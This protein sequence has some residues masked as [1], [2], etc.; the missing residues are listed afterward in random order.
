MINFDFDSATIRE[1]GKPVIDGLAQALQRC[2]QRLIRVE[3]HSD[4]IGSEQ[5]NLALSDR[6]AAAVYMYL[7]EH[8]VPEA[9]LESK[10]YGA[11]EPIASNETEEGRAKNRRVEIEPIN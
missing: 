8:G 5:Y 9:M 3:A 11:A 7:T 1:D 2:P 6:R 10:G 4:S